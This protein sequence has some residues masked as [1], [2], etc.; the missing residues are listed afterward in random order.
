MVALTGSS[1]F[2]CFPGTSVWWA[3]KRH[4]RVGSGLGSRAPGAVGDSG[5]GSPLRNC[6]VLCLW[7]MPYSVL[8]LAGEHSQAG[9][10]PSSPDLSLKVDR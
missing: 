9:L 2:M 5:P 10:A 8:L 3:D 6:E 4:G 1:A 7:L